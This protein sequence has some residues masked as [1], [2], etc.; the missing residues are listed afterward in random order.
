MDF[1]VFAL[2]YIAA[3]YIIYYAVRLLLQFLFGDISKNWVSLIYKNHSE[4]NLAKVNN[5]IAAGNLPNEDF[6]HWEMV[7]IFGSLLSEEDVS[8]VVKKAEIYGDQGWEKM[9]DYD[10][11]NEI[12]NVAR[13]VSSKGKKKNARKLL[14]FGQRLAQLYNEQEWAERYFQMLN[15][16]HAERTDLEWDASRRTKL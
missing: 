7:A 6:S 9:F 16:E 12:A 8:A 11:Y 15:R 4:V 3:I 5:F 10:F 13:K 1:F 2:I 14:M